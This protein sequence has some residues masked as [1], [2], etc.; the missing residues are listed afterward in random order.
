MNP[1]L[2]ESLTGIVVILL[3]TAV[4]FWLVSR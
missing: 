2:R 1:K 3:G 4:I